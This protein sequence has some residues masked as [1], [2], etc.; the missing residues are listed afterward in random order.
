MTRKP[1]P[2]TFDPGGR[3]SREEMSGSD[4]QATPNLGQEGESITIPK[5]QWNEIIETLRK[6]DELLSRL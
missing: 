2:P 5:N 1:R 3:E 6:T 4:H